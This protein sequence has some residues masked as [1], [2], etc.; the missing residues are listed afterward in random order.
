MLILLQA[1]R[2]HTTIINLGRYDNRYF[3]RGGISKDSKRSWIQLF[4]GCAVARIVC[5]LG[6]RLRSN[7]GRERIIKG[8]VIKIVGE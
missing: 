5:V 7:G 4:C 2:M 1:D 3:E 6:L 8:I